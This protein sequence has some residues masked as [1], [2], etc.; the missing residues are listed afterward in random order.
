VRIASATYS[1]FARLLLDSATTAVAALVLFTLLG[2]P[3]TLQAHGW[4]S[5]S[6]NHTSLAQFALHKVLEEAAPVFGDYVNV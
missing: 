5:G 6:K 1:P 2:T 3:N 4:F